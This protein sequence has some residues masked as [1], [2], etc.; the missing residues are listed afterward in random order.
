MKLLAHATEPRW[1]EVALADLDA[2][3]RDHLHCERKAAQSALSLVRQYPHR[4]DIVEVASRLAHE[5]TSH[6]LQVQQLLAD[7]GAALGYDAGNDYATALRRHIRKQEPDRLLDTLIVF[8][9]IEARSAERLGLLARHLDDRELAGTYATLEAAEH[10]HRDQFLALAA[11]T[12][13]DWEAR[14]AELA[15]QEAEIIRELPVRPRIH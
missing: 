6:V 15:A 4:A 5:E 8:A 14:A 12:S 11:A 3:F 1:I 13:P 2:V 7:R 9:L 10:R